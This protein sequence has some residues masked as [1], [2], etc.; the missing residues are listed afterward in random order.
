MNKKVKRK[1][2][3]KEIGYI[4]L[5]KMG[6]AMV[7]RLR[8]KGYRVVAWNRSEEPREEARRM[9]AEIGDTIEMVIAKLKKP[10]LVWLMLPHTAVDEML[11]ELVPY[12]SKGDTVID[13]GNSFYKDSI[14]RAKALAKKGINFLDVGTSGGP[15]GARNG[16]CL[17]IGGDQ[18]IFKG[19]EKLFKDL[20]AIIT[21]QIQHSDILQNVRMSLGG[22]MGGSYAYVGGS[23]AGHF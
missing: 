19:H 10:R 1:V 6:R 14:R 16:A 11:I 7:A 8:D 4:G 21:P 9:G 15:S 3:H 23:G 5:G 2:A 12:L 17:M 18:R 20:S 22:K 13:G